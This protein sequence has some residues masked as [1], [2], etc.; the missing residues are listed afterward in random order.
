M[1][2]T[3]PLVQGLMQASLGGNGIIG[4]SAPQMALA[5][6]T[7]FVNY[8]VG[9]LVATSV[10]VGTAGAGTGLSPT[11]ILAA[12]AVTGPL[13]GTLAAAGIN[14][15][16]R[17]SLANA[18]G[19]AVSQALVSAQVSTVNTGV[20][21]GTGKVTLV[22]N[23]AA[24]AA[25]MTAAFAGLGLVGI[26]APGMAVAV[27]QGIDA[28]LPSALAIVVIVGPPSTVSASGAGLGKVI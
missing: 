18:I 15:I 22:P 12:P 14:G 25:A 20:G 10:D 26:S 28:G 8:A 4:I 2:L 11:V 13:T 17:V 16:A 23:P 5:L 27:A 3:I 6:A 24:S 21:V 19:L 9:P 7:G 1:A